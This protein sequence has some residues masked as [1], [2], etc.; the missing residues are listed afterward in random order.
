MWATPWLQSIRYGASMSSSCRRLHQD[1]I[2]Y[3]QMEYLVHL[4]V[5][6]CQGSQ[7]FWRNRL[8]ELSLQWSLYSSVHTTTSLQWGRV[9]VCRE[10]D[11]HVSVSR[12]YKYR[13]RTERDEFQLYIVIYSYMKTVQYCGQYGTFR[14]PCHF[15]FLLIKYA[16]CQDFRFC[17]WEKKQ[18]A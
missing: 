9:A 5:V 12:K 13:P 1:T 6:H 14:Q 18:L 7:V 4:V 8:P 2:H 3:L 16:V 10:E 15:F 17:Q 11:V